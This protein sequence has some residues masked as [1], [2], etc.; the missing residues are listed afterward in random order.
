M[1]VVKAGVDGG[2]S[3][4]EKRSSRATAQSRRAGHESNETLP[5]Y[6]TT[7]PTEVGSRVKGVRSDTVLLTLTLCLTWHKE[8]VEGGEGRVF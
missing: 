7:G 2:K 1:F 8:S 3:W 4:G 5:R 6:K